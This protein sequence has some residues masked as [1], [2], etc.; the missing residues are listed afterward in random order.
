MPVDEAVRIALDVAQGLAA[1]HAV[2]A[3]HRDLKPS[4]ILFDGRRAR[5][6]GRPGAG[7]GAGRAEP[8][9]STGQP[10]AAAPRHAGLQEPGARTF[11]RPSDACL[12]RV[13]AGSPAVR[14]VDRAHGWQPAGGDASEVAVRQCAG[15]AG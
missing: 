15:M 6:G 9:R 11:H 4:N 7:A 14:D 1:L 5:Q 2:D 12:R 10:G 13:R 8:A 3:V